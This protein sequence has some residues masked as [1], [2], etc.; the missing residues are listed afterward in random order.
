MVIS[1]REP[2]LRIKNME[3]VAHRLYISIHLGVFNWADGTRYTGDFV[4]GNK[5]GQGI[6]EL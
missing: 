4:D 6:Y 2:G 5:H 3:K 1:T